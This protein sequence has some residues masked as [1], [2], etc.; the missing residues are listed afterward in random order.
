MAAADTYKQVIA[1]HRKTL[2]RLIQRGSVDRLKSTYDR[3][4]AEVLAKLN[5]LGRGSAPFTEHHL[6]MILAQLKAGQIHVADQMTT[7]LNKASRE[8]QVDSLHSLVRGYK[9]MEKHFTGHEPM[10]PLEEVARFSGVIDKRRASLMRQ[11]A[12]SVHRYGGVVI[13]SVQNEL[14]MSLATGETL[15][16]AI[17][18]VHESVGGEWWQA[19]R[20]ARTETA[21]AANVAHSDGIKEL[22]EER[23]DLMQQ[24]VEFCAP[25]GQPLDNRVGVDSI[26]MHGQLTV[27]GGVFVMPDRAPFPDAD[28]KIDVG[29]TL[30]G[31]TWMVPP[32]R[33]NGREMVQP[34]R[35]AWGTPGWYF[36]NGRRVP[37]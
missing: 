29:K 19:E 34:W 30:V 16:G 33:P 18:R 15:D 23:P 4:I 14:G 3:A 17:T 37:A 11:H 28:G 26:A 21:Y 20:I 7:T 6:R 36:R 8:A 10:L 13:D 32:C 1:A 9:A 12:T 35:K 24:W 31:Q 5:R 2:D 27:P 25:D 22:A